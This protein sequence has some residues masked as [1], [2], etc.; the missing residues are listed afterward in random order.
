MPTPPHPEHPSGHS[1]DCAGAAGV[2][3][4]A[5]GPG[6]GGI[7]HVATDAAPRA[8]RRFPSPA[9]AAEGCAM[10]RLWAGA[11]FRAAAQEGTRLG[12]AIAARA[13]AAAQPLA[14]RPAL[15]RD[16]PADTGPTYCAGWSGAAAD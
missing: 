6:P 9:A 10:S 8:A 14:G 13:L 3:S 11:H 1:A 12:G 4:G 5:F 15:M 16:R 2:L 7:T